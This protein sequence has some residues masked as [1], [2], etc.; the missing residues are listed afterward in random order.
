M[1]MRLYVFCMFVY[2]IQNYDYDV[3]NI[4]H[5]IIGN[6]FKSLCIQIN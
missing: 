5:N 1:Y 3:N 2:S 4:S 6:T